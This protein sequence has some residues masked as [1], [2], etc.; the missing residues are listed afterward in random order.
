MY[1]LRPTGTLSNYGI[2]DQKKGSL[3]SILT[4]QHEKL[5]S[6]TRIG[7]ECTATSPEDAHISRRRPPD[8]YL[9]RHIL[10]NVC[11]HAHM[12]PDQHIHMWSKWLPVVED[13][14]GN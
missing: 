1:T 5:C 4:P 14:L 11:L 13:V 6:K 7:M 8:K 12:T 3:E 2:E 10:V 9:D